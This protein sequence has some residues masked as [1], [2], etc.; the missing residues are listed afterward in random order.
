M[1]D[2]GKTRQELLDEIADLRLK[3]EELEKREKTTLLLLQNPTSI[4]IKTVT[5]G[6]ILFANE[7]ALRFFNYKLND[8]SGKKLDEILFRP[9]CE[10]QKEF[11]ELLKDIVLSPDAYLTIE[12]EN[13]TG[14]GTRVWIEWTVHSI[15]G[16]DG[17]I[18]EIICIGNDITR[19]RAI[20]EELR[21]TSTTDY[22]TGLLSRKVFIEKFELERYRY[23]RNGNSFVILFLSI[24]DL[25]EHAENFG[26]DCGDRIIKSASD[27]IVDSLRRTDTIARWSGEEIIMLL[28]ETGVDG[29]KAVAGKIFNRLSELSIDYR[30]Q[31][32][33][34]TVIL[35]VYS[36]ETDT[37]LDAI[38]ESVYE[39]IDRAESS[40]SPH[41]SV[42]TVTI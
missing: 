11:R 6:A 26:P 33:P 1:Q 3:I 17:T 42:A 22:V 24:I 12:S 13:I 36:Y 10:S 38:M 31:S 23:S 20:E 9:G 41:G 25:Q 37:E 19:R 8:V 14:D 35:C 40:D 21:S 5:D 32:I 16:A 7:Y 29:G 27:I 39:Y 4:I 30:H 15:T 34:V 2:N 18:T 28:P